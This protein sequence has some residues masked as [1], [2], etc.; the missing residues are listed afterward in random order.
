MT[1]KFH[2]GF[3]SIEDKGEYLLI[4]LVDEEFAVGDYLMLQR[5]YE[6]DEQDRRLGMDKVYIERNDQGYSC[7]GGIE[8]FELSPRSVRVRFDQHGS[9]RM[10]GTSEMEV[11]FAADRYQDLHAA[12]ERCF[13]GF[14][15]LSVLRPNTS[16]ERTREG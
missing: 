16:F 1:P 11:S 5:A 2:A 7:Y 8:S 4:G 12:L 6:F 15:C 9:E 14:S 10:G 13:E 3:V